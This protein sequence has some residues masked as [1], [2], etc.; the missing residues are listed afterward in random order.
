MVS[1]VSC[2]KS[3]PGKLNLMKEVICIPHPGL[4]A[5]QVPYIISNYLFFKK[6]KKNKK[7]F[8]ISEFLV[9]APK[10][11]DTKGKGIKLKMRKKI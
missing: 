1:L 11:Y 2:G 5:K 8:I 7:N 9:D 10:A 3:S 4:T 6:K